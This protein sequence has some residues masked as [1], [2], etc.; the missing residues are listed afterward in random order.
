MNS[1]NQ[2]PKV[3]IGI[4]VYNGEKFLRNALDCILNQSYEN[5]E[6]IISDDT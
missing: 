1:N 4:P 5:I 6:I 3:S 2:I